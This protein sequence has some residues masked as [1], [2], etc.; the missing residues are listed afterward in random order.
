MATPTTKQT[1]IDTCLRRLGHPVAEINVTEEQIDDRIT[2]ALDFY[3]DYH[4]DAT[5]RLYY[6]HVMT[7]NNRGDVVYDITVTTPGTL[8]SNS[9]VLVFTSNK[10]ENA[11]GT[12]TTDANGAIIAATLTDVGDGYAIAPTVTITTGTG[13][14][15][16][17]TAELGGFI[18][19]PENIIGAVRMFPIG[20]SNNSTNNIFSIRY[21]IALNDLYTLTSNSIV[22][23]YSAFQ[24]IGLIEEILVGQMPIRFNRHM[25][26]L[27]VDMDWNVAVPGEHIIIEAYR[28]IDPAVYADVWKDRWLLNYSTALIKLQWGNNLKKYSGVMLPGNIAL[29]GQQIYDEAEAEITKMETEMINA[30]SAPLNDFVGILAYFGIGIASTL[31]TL[32]YFISSIPGITTLIS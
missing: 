14:G 22:P 4:F 26:R 10:G 27:Y 20:D 31:A 28:V 29:N 30:Y 21:Q 5:E 17:I 13:S 3:A 9:D 18:P 32:N 15:G 7:A 1:H 11:A 25:N 16:L 23:Y 12:I 6:K 19:L 8:Y 2:Q 24:H